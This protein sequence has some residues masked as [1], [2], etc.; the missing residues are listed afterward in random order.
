[1]QEIIIEV[2][3]KEFKASITDNKRNEININGK[4]YSIELLKQIDKHIWSLAINNKI[5]QVEF[6]YQ[7]NGSAVVFLD[8][9]AFNINITDETKKLLKKYLQ[10]AHFG[11]NTGII[12][13][14]APMPGMIVKLLVNEGSKIRKGDAL[15]VIEA[16]KMENA[17]KSTVNGIVKKIHVSDQTAV[18]KGALLMEVESE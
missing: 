12:N 7:S 14:T 3:E 1:M 16:M 2:E 4:L 11:Q 9:M 5:C 17:I 13:I 10:D 8:G 15:I 18:E 6:D